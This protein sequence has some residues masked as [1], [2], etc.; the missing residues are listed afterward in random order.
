MRKYEKLEEVID[1]INE[2][3]IYYPGPQ[4]WLYFANAIG[5]SEECKKFKSQEE[6]YKSDFWANCRPLILSSADESEETKHQNFI[7]VI[8]YFYNTSPEQKRAVNTLL[9]NVNNTKW[10][11][12]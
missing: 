6:L 9:N 3:N 12:R 5:F 1:Y 2:N 4:Y 7:N 8:K 10:V 11:K